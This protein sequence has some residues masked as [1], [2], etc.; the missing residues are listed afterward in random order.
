MDTTLPTIQQLEVLPYSK[1]LEGDGSSSAGWASGPEIFVDGLVSGMLMDMSDLL[2]VD[3]TFSWNDYP[4]TVRAHG[5]SFDG[6]V[7]EALGLVGSERASACLRAQ[8]GICFEGLCQ[9]RL[10]LTR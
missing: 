8:P 5:L 1:L 7:G 10:P 6:K 9:T 2:P 3:S 4:K